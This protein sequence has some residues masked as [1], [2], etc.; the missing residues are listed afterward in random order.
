MPNTANPVNRVMWPASKESH[1]PIIE[2]IDECTAAL[3]EWVY[4]NVVGHDGLSRELPPEVRS[5]ISRLRAAS[6]AH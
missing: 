1:L 4:E 2:E 5:L 3:I 6:A